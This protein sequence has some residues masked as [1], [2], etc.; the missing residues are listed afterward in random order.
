MNPLDGGFQW[1][2]AVTPTGEPALADERYEQPWIGE[3]S[4]SG[5]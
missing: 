4:P 5:G 1:E 2:K 3:I